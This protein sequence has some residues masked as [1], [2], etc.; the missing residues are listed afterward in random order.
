MFMSTSFFMRY[1]Q[2]F[3]LAILSAALSFNALAA[4][5]FDGAAASDF[6][7]SAPQDSTALL[8]EQITISAGVK[9]VKN[10]PLRLQ[11]VDDSEIRSKAIG[12]TYPELLR[13]IPGIY[14]TAETGSYGDAKI[15]IRGF[16]QENI[17]V[18]LNGIPISGLT[19]GNMFWNNWLG[20]TD[21]T[22]TIQVQKGIGG[23]MLS[24]NSVGGTINIIT[25]S[26]I[27]VPAVEV[28]YSYT[29]YGLSKGHF[30]YNSG[31]L[32]KG[33]AFTLMGSYTWGHGYVECTDVKQGSYMLSLSKKFNE[34]HSLLF[35]ALGGPERHQQRSQR[36]TYAEFEKYGGSYSKNW[37]YYT[38]DNG[39][40]IAK[41]VSENVYFKPYFTL[42]HFYS[43]N[44]DFKL[45]TAAYFSIGDGGGV[46][47]E[48]KG[49]KILS[50]Q[51][52]GHIDWDA[53]IANNKAVSSSSS[54]FTKEGSAHNIMSD[55]MAGNLQIGVTSTALIDFSD[56]LNLE[57]GLHYQHYDTWEKEQITDLLGGSYWYEDYEKNSLMGLAGR[58]PYK[59]VGDYIRTYNGKV[60]NYGTLYAMLNFTSKK[61]ILNVG[62]SLNGSTHQRWDRYNYAGDDVYSDVQYKLGASVKAGAL[63]KASDRNSFYLNGALYSRVPYSSVIFANGNNHPSENVKNEKNLLGELGYRFVYSRGGVEATFYAAYW[64]NKSIMSNPYKPLEEDAYK[65]MITGLDAFHYGFEVDAF[66]NFGQWLRVDAY[67]SIGSWKWKNNVNAKIYDPYTDLVT[68]EVNVYSDGLPVGD[69]PQTQI[70][71]SLLARPF[72]KLS[73]CAANWLKEFSVGLNWQFNDRYWADFEPNTRTNP[74]D[75]ADPYRIPAY[76]L[77]NLQLSNTFHTSALDIQIFFNMNNLFNAEYII[78]GKDGA[79]HTAA[80]FTGY[81]G[82]A[83]NCNFGI[84]LNF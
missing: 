8:L 13:E 23:S 26:P 4:D 79:D 28:G 29:N 70:G 14:S 18:L 58:N 49:K 68:S 43:N 41:T 46:W 2:R 39:N 15:N 36:L 37:G 82:E 63:F 32:G 45:N 73:G 12:R 34:R 48:T 7:K 25:K 55:F 16:K 53:V 64:K 52:D 65:F 11:S 3:A 67:A 30:S 62:S 24:D 17:S 77:A 35:T 19:T 66:H 69:A 6:S 71:A 75:N 31:D 60:L 40:K 5:K 22:A 44:K 42:N 33:W 51:K 21:A 1:R 78:R 38:D 81:W 76:H 9:N 80:T 84:R 72:C 83:R 59:Q 54:G 20:L 74:N 10:S 61:W 56:K 47:T 57:A 27:A 50:Y